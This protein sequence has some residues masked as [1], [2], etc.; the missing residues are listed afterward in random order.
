M[1]VT[2]FSASN[3]KKPLGSSND[4]GPAGLCYDDAVS[5]A[6]QCTAAGAS[7]AAG[8]EQFLHFGKVG[9]GRLRKVFLSELK[10]KS[11]KKKPVR[12]TFPCIYIL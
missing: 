2:A 10:R 4:R 12:S 7:A 5:L 8:G 11:K 3:N 6:H 1:Y 9:Q